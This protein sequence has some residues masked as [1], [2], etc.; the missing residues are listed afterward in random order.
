VVFKKIFF[1]NITNQRSLILIITALIFGGIFFP[2]MNFENS[3]LVGFFINVFYFPNV[4]KNQLLFWSFFL[5]FAAPFVMDKILDSF[6][7]LKKNI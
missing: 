6:E 5:A 1:K 7:K 3:L 2:S 4:I